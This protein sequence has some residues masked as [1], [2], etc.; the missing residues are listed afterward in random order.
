MLVNIRLTTSSVS[1]N[2]PA[3]GRLGP[4]IKLFV[5]TPNS[6]LYSLVDLSLRTSLV[7]I[8]VKY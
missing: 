1:C 3:A 5:G 2:Y 8:F 4:R 7:L 6:F